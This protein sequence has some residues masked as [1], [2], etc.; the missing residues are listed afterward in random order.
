MSKNWATI[1]NGCEIID[2]SSDILNNSIN[3]ILHSNLNDLWITNNMLPQWFCLHTGMKNMKN[4]D[5]EKI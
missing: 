1:E 2:F 4:I 5:N 3:N